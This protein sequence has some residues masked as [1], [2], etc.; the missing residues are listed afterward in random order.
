MLFVNLM[1]EESVGEKRKS[2]DMMYQ[3]PDVGQVL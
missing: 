1:R 2:L 3:N